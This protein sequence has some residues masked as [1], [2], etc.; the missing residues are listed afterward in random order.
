RLTEHGRGEVG[1]NELAGWKGH[2]AI[3]RIEN[4]RIAAALRAFK[5]PVVDVSAA[6]LLPELPWVETDDGAIARA[7]ADH[8]LARGLRNFGYCGDNRFNWSRWRRGAF[9]RYLAR[10]GLECSDGP[11]QGTRGLPE[12]VRALPK[13]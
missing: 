8:L 11:S 9:R 2:G 4:E 13:P 6:R 10:V 12:W 5:R 3:A 1:R 7:A